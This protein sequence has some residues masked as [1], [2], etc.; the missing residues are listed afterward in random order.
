MFGMSMKARIAQKS[1]GRAQPLA[2]FAC[3]SGELF[4]ELPAR[5]NVAADPWQT[6]DAPLYIPFSLAR[7][8][9]MERL[10]LQYA[11]NPLRHRKRF[12]SRV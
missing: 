12:L 2:A 6:S 1:T 4:P 7:S 10:G 9:R 5:I 3:K 8:H 11:R